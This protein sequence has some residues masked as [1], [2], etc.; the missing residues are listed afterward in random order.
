M[1]K[2]LESDG[3]GFKREPIV[4]A[5]GIVSLASPDVSIVRRHE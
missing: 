2:P 4:R 1:S 3:V 5:V